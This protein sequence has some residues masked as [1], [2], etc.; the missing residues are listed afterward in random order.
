M[1][2]RHKR[3]LWLLDEI[4]KKP[5]KEIAFDLKVNDE[6]VYKWLKRIRDRMAEYQ[7]YLNTIYAKQRSS[8]RVKKMTIDGSLEQEEE[9]L[10]IE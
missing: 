9:G 2:K 5:V 7:K 4:A 6:A 3:D 1:F 8:R 10:T